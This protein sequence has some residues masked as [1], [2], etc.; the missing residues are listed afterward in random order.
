MVQQLWTPPGVVQRE[1]RRVGRVNPD[2]TRDSVFAYKFTFTY[3]GKIKIIELV[4]DDDTSRAEM[5]DMAAESAERW[6]VEL[7]GKEHKKIPS[8]K[9][10]KEIAGMLE[11]IRQRR[12]KMS[13]SANNKTL[14]QGT[15]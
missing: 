5:E 10:K 6:K 3:K 15:K 12:A 1:S 4:T 2:V 13:E 14:F 7:D 11:D 8:Q 9:E